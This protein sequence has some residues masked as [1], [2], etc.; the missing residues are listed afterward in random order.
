MAP[1]KR[2][3]ASKNKSD[4]DNSSHKSECATSV[5]PRS[6][7]RDGR[8]CLHDLPVEMQLEVHCYARGSVRLAD[9]LSQILSCLHPRDLLH[10]AQTCK[11]YRALTLRRSSQSIWKAAWA[12]AGDLPECPAFISEPALIHLLTS[13]CC[14]VSYPTFMTELFHSQC[15]L[16]E[17]MWSLV[18]Q[19]T[20]SD[21]VKALLCP[22]RHKIVIV[23]YCDRP[24]VSR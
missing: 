15:G 1:R 17:E 8:L 20:Y 11:E 12:R 2:S 7:R 18:S 21:V 6:T 23:V 4:V 14:Q 9:Y 10:L 3:K 13:S 22:L 19:K 24:F 16:S 5:D